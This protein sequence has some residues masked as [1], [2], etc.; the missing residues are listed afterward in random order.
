MAIYGFFAWCVWETSLL[1][2][3]IN[4]L[5]GEFGRPTLK[6]V[7]GDLHGERRRPM[8]VVAKSVWHGENARPMIKAVN[9]VLPCSHPQ[10]CVLC[11]V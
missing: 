5:H 2:V 8:L 11:R 10:L 6:V 4:A 7:Y 3:V 9:I 1:S